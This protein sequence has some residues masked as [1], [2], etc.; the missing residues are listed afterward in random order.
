MWQG[1][2]T[3]TQPYSAHPP[4][5][6]IMS[7]P[8][9]LSNEEATLAGEVKGAMLNDC[10]ECPNTL[11]ARGAGGSS[12]PV[13]SELVTRW[14]SNAGSVPP[15]PRCSPFRD[16]PGVGGLDALSPAAH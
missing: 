14:A 8:H 6:V 12:V 1:E 5:K 15:I 13:L 3:S 7:P 10:W 16:L 2:F 4:H 9:P 11:M